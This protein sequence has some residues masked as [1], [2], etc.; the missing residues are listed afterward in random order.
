MPNYSD[1][2]KSPDKY[3]NQCYQEGDQHYR[4]IEPRLRENWQLYNLV[5]DLLQERAALDD[6][7]SV[8]FIP[9]IYPHTESRTATIDSE[10]LSNQDALKFKPWMGS[11]NL[12][13]KSTRLNSSH[14]LISYAVFC[15]KK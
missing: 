3:K 10:V 14:Q 6:G 4:N 7:R 12:D 11:P 2:E 13:Q 5:S 9:L 8:L 15:L 1:F